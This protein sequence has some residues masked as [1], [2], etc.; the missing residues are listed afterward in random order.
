MGGVPERVPL[1]GGKTI[2]VEIKDTR[3]TSAALK[4]MEMQIARLDS[5]I[6]AIKA[7]TRAN[8]KAARTSFS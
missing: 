3:D 8:E 1:D 5:V 7:N 4:M 2:P 6:E